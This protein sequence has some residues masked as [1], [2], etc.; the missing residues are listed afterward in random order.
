MTENTDQ[1]VKVNPQQ[2]A[3]LATVVLT[4]LSAA[5][6]II[7]DNTY[8]HVLMA[9]ITAIMIGAPLIVML[10]KQTS[11]GRENEE[12]L[13]AVVHAVEQA[14]RL[15]KFYSEPVLEEM[16]EREKT[17]RPGVIGKWKAAVKRAKESSQ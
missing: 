8:G 13:D 6:I 17:S 12:A 10:L 15:N 7:P 11:W 14:K 3:V 9:V 2:I 1:G 16:R 4:V 5:S